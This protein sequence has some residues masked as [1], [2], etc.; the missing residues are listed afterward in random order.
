MAPAS[1][2]SGGG[3]HDI[4]SATRTNNNDPFGAVREASLL[5]T[6]APGIDWPLW[7][8]PDLCTLYYINKESDEATATATLMVT[9]RR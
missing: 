2:R 4:Y 5:S 3:S 9:S 6:P 1:N 7:L 8:S